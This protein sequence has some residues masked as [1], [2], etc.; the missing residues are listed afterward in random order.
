[1]ADQG[2]GRFE[3][4]GRKMD[5]HFGDVGSRFEDEL[6]RVISY[7]NDRVV[8]EVRQNSSA[9]LRVAAEQLSRLA[10]NLD[11]APRGRST[12]ASTPPSAGP[13]NPSSPS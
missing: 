12:A 11:R 1:M 13:S 5:E 8:P 2:S 9:A 10:E 4:M 3:H 6:R 7:I